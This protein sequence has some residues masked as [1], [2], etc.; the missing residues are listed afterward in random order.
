MSSTDFGNN[1]NKIQRNM[2]DLKGFNQ[3]MI[4]KDIVPSTKI[5]NKY[6]REAGNLYAQVFNI[7]PDDYLFYIRRLCLANDEPVSLEEI[8][9]PQYLV[10][11][12]GGINL[13]M[14]S[15][16]ETYKM[17]GINLYRADETLDLV[18]PDKSDA[19]LLDI[20]EGVPTLFFQSTSYDDLG[21]VIEFNKNYVRGDKCNFN[22]HFFQE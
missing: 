12:M 4:E 20:E 7:K 11:K 1:Q 13:N 3:T 5:L 17:F 21:R 2:D 19:K 6:L 10:P 22:V 16:Y 18:I 15:I 14:F 8:Y 9:I